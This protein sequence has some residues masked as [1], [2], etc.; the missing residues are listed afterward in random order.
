LKFGGNSVESPQR[1]CA[2]IN[3]INN[4]ELKIV[5]LSALSGITNSLVEISQTLFQK[6][7]QYAEKQVK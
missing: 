6:E 4:G 1:I 7:Q 3:L 5:M 2:L